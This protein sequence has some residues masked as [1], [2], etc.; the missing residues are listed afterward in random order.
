MAAPETAGASLALAPEAALAGATLAGHGV[1]VIGSRLERGLPDVPNHNFSMASGTGASRGGDVVTLWK[2]PRPGRAGLV[3]EVTSGFD[4][5]R[6]PGEGP[7][8]TTS[9]KVAKEYQ[10]K[11][12]N[13]LQEIYIPKARYEEFRSSGVVRDDWFE[14]DS[15]H[16]PADG[17]E[18]FNTALRSGLPNAYYPE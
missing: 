9:K 1:T 16:V 15:V 12:G 2:A 14:V 3:D 11:Y 17:L 4:P 5:A 13:G 6:C 10:F 7:F 18:S 8:F